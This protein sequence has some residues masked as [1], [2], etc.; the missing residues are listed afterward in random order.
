[1]NLGNDWNMGTA[2]LHDSALKM[3]ETTRTMAKARSGKDTMTFIMDKR[4][5]IYAR[6]K[7]PSA[8]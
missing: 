5:I 7:K 1:M 8:I 3:T 4:K 6:G 2:C